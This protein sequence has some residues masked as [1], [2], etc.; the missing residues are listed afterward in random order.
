MGSRSH[1]IGLRN[2]LD[3]KLAPFTSPGTSPVALWREGRTIDAMFAKLASTLAAAAAALAAGT[4]PSQASQA[5]VSTPAL[6]RVG[7]VGAIFGPQ[8]AA[9]ALA[10]LG[11]NVTQSALDEDPTG[12]ATHT[13]LALPT[14]LPAELR[15]TS[16][17]STRQGRTPTG[18]KS[19]SPAASGAAA[20]TPTTPP[21]SG[22]FAMAQQDTA[23][24]RTGVYGNSTVEGSTRLGPADVVPRP[25]SGSPAQGP[26]AVIGSPTATNAGPLV[27]PIAG[28]RW[29][30]D[31]WA[32]ARAG[33]RTHQGTDLFAK[34]GVPVVTVAAAVV[35]KVDPVDTSGPGG[36]GDLGGITVSYVT[37]RGD[38][39]YNAHLS[40][41]APGLRPG[42]QLPAG[43]VI[44]AVGRTGDARTTP[45]HLHLQWHPGGGAPVP[46]F[47]VLRD[48]CH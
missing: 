20:D 29:F 27:C 28:P 6:K 19:K 2:G 8:A 16:S 14:D 36:A 15:T 35:V 5:P 48:A 37:S 38:R 22:S 18:A 21:G 45:P 1:R 32:A 26:G 17:F 31:T 9:D 47:T 41:V 40:S 42:A 39:W 7:T 44:G 11:V 10:L 46:N 3:E 24:A 43:S 34:E 25:T 30:T 13:A 23:G 33:G 12:A 4:A